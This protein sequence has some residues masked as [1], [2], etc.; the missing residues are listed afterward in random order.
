VQP[1]R[2]VEALQPSPT[3]SSGQDHPRFA[4]LL[5]V[6]DEAAQLR[7]LTRIMQAEGFEVLGCQTAAAALDYLQHH[8]VGVAIID[9]R[10][11]DLD[12]VCLVH[13]IREVNCTARIIV[14]TAYS[15]F[16]SAKELL[17]LGTFAYVE[18]L[19]D[20]QELMGH[21]H[22]AMH[23][24]L[25][26][27]A[28]TLEAAVAA[29]TRELLLAKEAA[30]QANCAKSTFLA[31]MSH[32]LRT[33]LGSI[34]GFANLLR[35]NKYYSLQAQDLVYLERIQ[36]NGTHLLSLINAMLD[37][38]K[39][40]AGQSDIQMTQI[41]LN[42]LIPEVL[43]QLEGSKPYPRVPLRAALP[44]TIAPVL[45]DARKLK[46]ILINLVGNALK[47]TP[48]GT[49]TVWVEVEPTTHRP[50]SINV[51]DTGIGIPP[52]RC[53][54]IFEHFQQADKSTAWKYG[55]TGLG[56]AI[57]RA[58]CQLLGYQLT[59]ESTVG[60]GSTFRLMMPVSSIVLG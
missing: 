59:V 18:K 11:P 34:I 24:H 51:I 37:L 33:P 26:Q 15:S 49:V 6:E 8:D 35:K 10:L 41:A 29:R 5:I 40:E 20:P 39:I 19:G 21:V 30:E 50:I 58:L 1:T 43:D 57:S 28:A 54:A 47:F 7:T 25:R 55:G 12:G 3:G 4:G 16:E 44:P 45:T 23:E 17:N 32:E 13:R 22:R 31:D 36:A 56:L 48:E 14:H 27:Y 60:Q 38:S 52:E 9:L 53:E 46:Q 2:A 42:T